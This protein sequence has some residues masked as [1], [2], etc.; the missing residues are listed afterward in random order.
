[1][2]GPEL[3]VFERDLARLVGAERAFGVK[4]GTDAII[5]GLEALGVGPGDEV[6]TTPFTYF[7][8]IEAIV[9]AGATPVLADIDPATLC[10]DLD[11]CA[12]AITPRTRAIILVHLFG[13]CGDLD[14]FVELCNARDLRLVEDAAQA[15]GATWHGRPLG[16]LGSVAT[17]SFYPTKNLA[18]L[19]DGG[20]V[21]TSH[22]AAATRIEQLR[23]HGCDDAGRHVSWGWNSRLDEIQAAFLSRALAGLADDT[24]RRR[25]IA[26]RYNEALAGLVTLVGGRPGCESCHHQYAILLPDRDRL[27]AYLAENGVETGCYYPTPVHCEPVLA[28]QALSFPNAERA[29]REVLNL[30]IRASLTGAEQA[31]VTG[32]IDAFLRQ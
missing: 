31:R 12:A 2:F 26:R 11:A 10:L 13:H 15:L 17:F 28:G 9:R 16:S 24:A 6:I 30:P 7:A 29:S 21:V 14:G 19:G 18:A 25:E 3:A 27:R 32:L 4:S 1:M 22:A 20:A 23:R 8:T 5:L